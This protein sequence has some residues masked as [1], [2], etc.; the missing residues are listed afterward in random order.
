LQKYCTLKA[1][2][3]TLSPSHTRKAGEGGE[4]VII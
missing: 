4:D 3:L 2:A 1:T